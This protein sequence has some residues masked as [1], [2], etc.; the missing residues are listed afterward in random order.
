MD[1]LGISDSGN[2]VQKDRKVL[3]EEG[4]IMVVISYDPQTKQM[5]GGPEVIS[6]GFVYVKESGDL[7]EEIKMIAI[8]SFVKMEYSNK[9]NLIRDNIR[10]FVYQK[11][12]KKPMVLPVIINVRM[13]DIEG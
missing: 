3:S 10:D 8:E 7:M 12:K 4:L 11:T 9:K 1:G 5:V 2:V 13:P 6:R